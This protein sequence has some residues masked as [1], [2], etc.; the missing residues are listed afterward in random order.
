MTG[1]QTCALPIYTVELK[2]GSPRDVSHAADLLDRRFDTYMEVPSPAA[3]GD[4]LAA[5]AGTK[6]KAKVRTGGVTREAFPS[7]ADVVGFIAGCV[8]HGVAFK[9]TAGLHHPWRNEYPLTYAPDA[10]CGT[11]FGF[12]NVLLS[13]AALRAAERS[14]ERR[15]GK[16]CRSRWSPYH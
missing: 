7:S 10:P 4:I 14:E 12:L 15:V 16:E 3:A 6:A 2:A 11:M 8:A 9:A 13:A 1:V 5:I